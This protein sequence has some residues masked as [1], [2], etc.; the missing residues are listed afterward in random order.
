MPAIIWECRV[1]I[2]TVLAVISYVV[3]RLVNWRRMNTLEQ[4]PTPGSILVDAII[5]IYRQDN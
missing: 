5:E 3:Y 2:I 1:L 4:S